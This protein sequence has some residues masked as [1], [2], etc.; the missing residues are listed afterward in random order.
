MPYSPAKKVFNGS[1]LNWNG[2][3][4]AALEDVEWHVGGQK[5]DIGSAMDAL[6]L[7]GQGLDDVEVSFTTKGATDI[8]RGDTGELSIDFNDDN[9]PDSLTDALVNDVVFSGAKNGPITSKIQIVP[10]PPSE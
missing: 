5:V 6:M 2:S 10:A 8:A 4:V 7:Y 3:P 9:N 1:T